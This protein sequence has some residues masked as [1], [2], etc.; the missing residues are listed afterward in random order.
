MELN[1]TFLTISSAVIKLFILMSAGYILC[2]LKVIDEKFTDT[3]GMLLVRVIFPALII[4]KIITDFSYAD[5]RNWWVFPLL[6]VIFA[7]AGMLIGVL[8]RF[9]FKGIGPEK[10]FIASCGFQNCGYLP[11][12][13]IMFAFSGATEDRLLIY[14]FLFIVGFN[15][16]MWSLGPL[17]FAGGVKKGFKHK[18]LLN[19]PV[20]A[21]VFSLLWVAIGGKGSMPAILMDP[22]TRLGQAAFPLAM[23]TL[24]SY[25]C[26]HRAHDPERIFPLAVCGIIKLIV[27]PAIVLG[28]L[29]MLNI[30]PDVKFFLFLE[31]LMPVAVSLVIIGSFTGAD[32]KFLSSI[33]FYTHIAAIF[34]IPLWLAVFNAVG[35]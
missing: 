4:S 30:S 9:L 14:L 17:F 11:M 16:L 2:A 12:T 18:L 20:L 34:T 10:E 3:L 13:L 23:I 28:A 1:F 31:S 19:P 21:T 25:L 32:N 35:K 33:I 22:V 6:A 27:L 7:A 29:L 15:L 26:S 24:G 8:A 5:Y